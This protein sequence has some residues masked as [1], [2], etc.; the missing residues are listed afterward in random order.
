MKLATV[1]ARGGSKGVPGKN[2]RKLGGKSLV[3]R[4]VKQARESGEFDVIAVSSDDD[5]ILAEGR[6]AG[7]DILVKRPAELSSDVAGKIP[8]IRHCV[9]FVERQQNAEVDYVCD[10]AVTS[11]MRV[12]DDIRSAMS[13]ILSTK[14]A[15]V[16]SAHEATESPYYTMIKRTD[17]GEWE[18]FSDLARKIVRRQ[19][20]PIV[21]VLNGAVY[22]WQRSRLFA[23]IKYVVGHGT[24]VYSMPRERGID[25]DSELDLEFAEFLLGK[26]STN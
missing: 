26:C 14:A 21:Y 25:I 12:V 2:L 17:D 22:V 6:S 11:P 8:A 10:I 5:R 16:V 3:E 15:N 7:A 13:L 18:F 19:D 23:D 9:Q 20:A 1:L 24:E 4:A